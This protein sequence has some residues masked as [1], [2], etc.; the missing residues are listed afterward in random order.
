M[1]I[2]PLWGTPAILDHLRQYGGDPPLALE[3]QA[4]SN[5]LMDPLTDCSTPLIA[6]HPHSL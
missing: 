1:A 2:Y 6:S 5:P 4:E 3:N